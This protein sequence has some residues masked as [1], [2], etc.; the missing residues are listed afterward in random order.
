MDLY[1]TRAGIKIPRLAFT[2]VAAIV[3]ALL[4]ITMLPSGASAADPAADDTP[5]TKVKERPDRVSA[6]S[7][8][9]AQKSRV[10]DLSARTPTTSSYAN[11]D[12]SWTLDTYTAPIRTKGAGGDWVDLDPE[13][14]NGKD[15]VS[16][17]ASALPMEFSNGGDKT[18]AR[19]TS[20][21][22]HKLKFGW[23]TELKKPTL[24]GNVATYPDA[25]DGGDL[26]VTT[27]AEGFSHDVVLRQAP[28]GDEPLELRLPLGLDGAKASVS[29][30]G[31]IQIKDGKDLVASAPA[32]VMFENSD[33]DNVDEADREVT[34]IETSIE[35]TGS[36][37]TLVLKPDMDFL[38]D[39]T[40][41]YPLTIDP[42]FVITPAADTW[43]QST[44]DTSSQLTSPELRVGSNDS[45][46]TKARSFIY[47]DLAF[48]S[49]MQTF[50]VQ[51]ANLALSNFET[52]SCTGTNTEV[53]RVTGGWFTNSVTWA[54]QPAVTA[55]GAATSSGS[56]GTT[57]CA[58]ETDVSFD[59]KTIFESWVGGSTNL[60]V[61]VA[62]TNE[63]AAS[64]WRKFRAN[65]S[66]MAT[67]IPRLTVTYNTAPATPTASAVAPSTTDGSNQLTPAKRPT[68]SAS[69]TDPDGGTLTPKFKLTQGATTVEETTLPTVT[70]GSVAS[71]KVPSDLADGTYEVRWQVSDGIAT[72]AWTDP[73]SVVVDST[74]PPA[75]TISCP[76]T[77][78]LQW[79]DTKPASSTTCT[80]TAGSGTEAITATLNG[81]GVTFPA[82]S[83]GA[84]SK[85][86]TL[87]DDGMFDLKVV[88]RDKAG[89]PAEKSYTFGIGNG[90]LTA[91]VSSARSSN[92]F[93]VNATSKSGAT[94]AAL[95]WRLA[96]T[97]TWNTA[98][99]VQQGIVTWLGLPTTSGNMSTTGD[100]TWQASAET[101]VAN[102]SALDAR[103]CFNYSG[104]PAQRCT[105]VSQVNLVPH[106]FG[107]SFP[108]A[109][110]GP[111]TVALMSGEFQ[112]VESDVSVPSYDGTLSLTRTYQ[113]FGNAASPAQG[114]FGPGW[115]ANLQGPEEGMAGTQVVDKTATN[116]TISL[117]D[118]DGS[119]STYLFATG[120]TTAQAVGVYKGQGEAAT[121][122]E[123]LEIKAGS[124]KTLELTDPVGTITSWNY[125]GSNTWTVS[126]VDDASTAP[127]ETYSYSGGLVTG[128]YSAAPGATCNATTQDKGCR[129]LLLNYTAI[130]GQQR[131]TSVNLKIW[132]PK[133]TSAGE[134]GASA[135]MESIVVQQYAYDSNG[136]LIEAWDPRKTITAGQ[137]LKTSYTYQTVASNLYLA[138]LTRPGE[139]AWNFGVDSSGRLGTL[140]RQQDSAVGGGDA[141]WTV[142]Y[143]VPLSGSGLPNL[144]P[145]TVEQWGQAAAPD[146]ATAIFGP[147]APNTT[148]MSYASISYF[149]K[150]GRITN[151]AMFGGDAWQFDAAN[152]DTK[153]NI[154]WSI[155]PGNR[156]TAA[157]AGS[158]GPALANL[159]GSSTVYNSSGTRVESELGP[160]RTVVLENYGTLSGRSRTDYV[161]DDEAA[162]EGVPVPGRPTPS[163]DPD[164]PKPNLVVEKRDMVVD[165]NGTTYDPHKTR[166]R[167]DKV[168]STDGDGWALS[169]PTRVSTSLGSGW[170]TALTRFDS[171]GKVLETRTPQGVAS[172]D[173]AGSDT[174]STINTYFTADGSSSVAACRNHAEWLGLICQSGLAS[175]T[176]STPTSTNK[177][178][179]YLL[180]PTRVEETSSPMTRTFVTAFD[181]SGRRTAESTVMAGAP[182]SDKPVDDR[183]FTYS[184]S[185]GLLT[186]TSAGGATATTGYDTWGRVTSQ[187]D[188]AGNT[189]ATTY[190]GSS[191]VKTLNDGKGT[192]TYTYNGT[193][194]LGRTERRGVV[195]K[196]DVGLASGPDEFAVAYDGN[197]QTRRVTYPNGM[198]ADTTRDAVGTELTR[199]Y[200]NNG[201]QI[202]AFSRAVDTE[203][204]TRFNVTPLS[205]EWDNYD[206]RD[207][208]TS[209]LENVGGAGCTTRQYT[210]SLDS[211][212]TS[213][214]TSGPGAGGECSTSSPTTVSP[215]YFSD[216]RVGDTGYIYDQF[217]RTRN[218]PAADTDQTS[219]SVAAI[220]YY[221]NDMVARIAQQV[222]ATTGAVVEKNYTPDAMGRIGAMSYKSAGVELRKTVN[223][224]GD[225]TDTPAWISED[226]RP[227]SSTAWAS[228]WTR[229]IQDPDGGVGMIQSSDGSAKIQIT[230]LHGDIVSTVPNSTSLSALSNYAETNEYGVPRAG[231]VALGQ[232]YG[233]LGSYARS[234]DAI[235]G[236][237]LMGARLYNPRTGRFLSRD[238]IPGGNDNAYV[239]SV[240]PINTSD[241]T[242]L[243]TKVFSPWF[244]YEVTKVKTK[245]H[246]YACG[247]WRQRSKFTYEIESRYE[248]RFRGSARGYYK[249]RYA[250]HFRTLMS[251]YIQTSQRFYYRFTRKKL[252]WWEDYPWLKVYSSREVKKWSVRA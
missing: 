7:T 122:N 190:D 196:V 47:F 143:S 16:P 237:T 176:G 194:A 167:Y 225:D 185:N 37:T 213:V 188:G 203:S 82:L 230:N 50:T 130:G 250:T 116:G 159:L 234:T 61:R 123:K 160:T 252:G 34:P 44:G 183:T 9:Q 115:I 164:L 48:I 240:D 217:G 76:S 126:D 13:L 93:V 195:T 111:A 17:K 173:G 92:S 135:A 238:P 62:A 144:E 247:C 224:Y 172:V 211:N 46:T 178:F 99:H 228:A 149:T 156:A 150:E 23:P 58:T 165:G 244:T 163:S 223:H 45:G 110:V 232:N 107:D 219:G 94:T 31:A 169:T 67:K 134:S 171:E 70:S 140:T 175:P 117:I 239:Y 136:R 3:A 33:T 197:G 157:A 51:S 166:N 95:Q 204:R 181:P 212:R 245:W 38:K 97:T 42:S 55:T 125:A 54:N 207:R 30:D 202:A 129:A 168:V 60:G 14:E 187:T 251:F 209:V 90:A 21:D 113:S 63:T 154:V 210:L 1:L 22:G 222:P 98:T 74:P 108:N 198:T 179:D 10:E 59:V 11:P 124:P 53:S 146:D 148:D 56:F 132:N 155:T 24:D 182:S 40:T 177:G 32:P 191:R 101:G 248:Y 52:G 5:D 218:V 86:F 127:D 68:F 241:T 236:L 29:E 66:G 120:G 106:A 80:V 235:G 145:A 227:N 131:L 65:D 205:A 170:S 89:N 133:P 25:V 121:R 57:G 184:S 180:N 193:D 231:S 26:V 186:A 6:M 105:A 72:S 4:T 128:I 152:Y 118:D 138:S 71:R 199:T 161:Y 109:D 96:G 200:A 189:T 75:P 220:A 49:S 174:R 79:Y 226:T 119:T 15:G 20:A 147:E 35:G 229:N 162:S 77:T 91:P 2:L 64:G 215:G 206:G 88:A 137:P 73:L 103:V 208:L 85:S 246:K 216:D 221:A 201:N 8:A 41:T 192:Y 83:G 249:Y 242:G 214:A 43:V 102:P 18:F 28:T 112:T 27:N 141:T 19:V 158:D 153:G 69:V 100:L 78:N 87:P 104:S 243:I 12:G 81:A 142:S 233:W 39:P 114:V 151:E 139:K 36:D 84:T